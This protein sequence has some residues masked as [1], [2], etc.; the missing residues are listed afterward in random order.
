MLSTS[1]GF[2]FEGWRNPIILSGS[3]YNQHLHI[4]KRVSLTTKF[5]ASAATDTRSKPDP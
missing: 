2:K 1:R 5:G 4:T 3:G